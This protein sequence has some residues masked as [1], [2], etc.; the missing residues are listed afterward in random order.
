MKINIDKSKIYKYNSKN[1]LL[2]CA[3]KMLGKEGYFSDYSDF[4]HFDTGTLVEI[5]FLLKGSNYP[6]ML[7]FAGDENIGF[8]YFIPKDTIVFEEEPCY[9]PYLHTSELP[10]KTGDVITVRV[11]NTTLIYKFLIS[12][13]T[14]NEHTIELINYSLV[15]KDN[16]RFSCSNMRYFFNNYELFING[17]WQIFG[18]KYEKD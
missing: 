17:E 14:S 2:E 13:I 4:K 3:D 11:K 18:V 7:S 5:K 16:T 12:N 6:F 1:D 10:F 9:R 15:D 8:S